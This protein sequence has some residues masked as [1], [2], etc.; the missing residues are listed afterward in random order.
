MV[1]SQNLLL[2]SISVQTCYQLHREL[3]FHFHGLALNLENGDNETAKI[4][5]MAQRQKWGI[6]GI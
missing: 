3:T 4:R 5:G 1:K 2:V 6:W